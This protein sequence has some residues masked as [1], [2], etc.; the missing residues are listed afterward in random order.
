MK[1]HKELN[2]KSDLE[3]NSNKTGWLFVILI[4]AILLLLYIISIL[5]T[6]CRK[7][8]FFQYRA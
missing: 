2:I 1:I 6:N 7:D 5:V 3:G 4:S 8:G